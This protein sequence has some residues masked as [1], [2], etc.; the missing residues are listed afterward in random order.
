MSVHEKEDALLL[1][2]TTFILSHLGVSEGRLVLTWSTSDSAFGDPLL[3]HPPAKLVPVQLKPKEA[4]HNEKHIDGVISNLVSET[5]G[6][7]KETKRAS[8]SSKET[9]KAL[10]SIENCK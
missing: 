7:I 5:E 6:L 8:F 4:L 2:V 9:S 10:D 1:S 3:P